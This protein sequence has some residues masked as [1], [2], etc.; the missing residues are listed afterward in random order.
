MFLC[1]VNYAWNST[2]LSEIS[3]F[4]LQFSE[5]YSIISLFIIFHLF[6]LSPSNYIIHTLGISD[7]SS[8]S[9]IILLM[10]SIAL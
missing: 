6:P 1:H 7:L 5:R 2:V 9:H 8:I 4:F 3:S 10:F